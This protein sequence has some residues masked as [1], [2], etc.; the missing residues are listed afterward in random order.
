MHASV[1]PITAFV[2]G[3]AALLV[4]AACDIQKSENP[5]SPS[6]AGPLPGVT[7]TTPAPMAPPVGAQVLTTQLP[8]EIRFTN[9]TSNSPRPFWHIVE[10]AADADFANIIYR[11]GPLTPG[12][13]GNSTHRLPAG[14]AHG[15]TYFWRVLAQDGA[16]ES[17]PSAAG[18]FLVVE[19][20][21]IDTPVPIEPVGGATTLS[22]SPL[23]VVGDANV[24]GPA[25]AVVYRVEAATD[26][27]FASIVATGALPR[28]GG[29]TTSFSLGAFPANQVF[30]WRTWGTNGVVTSPRSA[31]QSFRTPTPGPGP[32][33]GP[34]PSD[35]GPAPTGGYRTPDPPPGQNLPL[36]N[37][38]HIVEQ[39][40]R[41]FP[42]ALR[43]SCQEHGGTWEFMDRVVDRLRLH[44][45]RWGYNWK[46]G[47]V[48]DPS[49]DVV[50]YHYGPGSDEGATRVYIIDVIG[51][52]CGSSPR[53]SWN[54]VTQITRDAGAIGR[55]TGRGRF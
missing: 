13:S 53:P 15:R 19:P 49:L 33:P 35:P 51:G 18:F 40:A 21:I 28:T 7:I 3:A 6:I 36:P 41:E 43:R 48:G 55:W 29:G 9:A 27:N 10:L 30:Y 26:Q 37:M 31:T 5:L 17:Q 44:D 4:S 11:S 34:G 23:F 8:L 14:L 45:T 47:R 24:S 32:G 52:H 1:R 16:N 20:V 38:A 50:D 54:D 22:S 39:V 12:E 2:L 46:R 25:G 42:S